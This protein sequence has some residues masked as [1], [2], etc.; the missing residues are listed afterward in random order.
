MRTFRHDSELWLPCPRSELFPFFADARNLQLITPLWLRF[1]VL[2]EGEI[3][4]AEG[5]LI[6]YRLRWRGLPLRW[7]TEITA[8]Q[9]PVRFVDEQRRGPYRL[10]V[11]EHLFSER[12][13]GTLVEDRV[14]YA[15]PGGLLAQRLLVGAD[16][17]RIFRFRQDELLHRFG[18]PLE[19]IEHGVS[20]FHID[21]TMATGQ[22]R[23]WLTSSNGARRTRITGGRSPRAASTG[24][25][26]ATPG[27]STPNE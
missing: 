24:S 6:D 11:H 16:V 12:D 7:Q 21:P 19:V 1:S 20:G 9:P 2:T 27:G 10:W 3:P 23:R 18:G 4:M 15:V 5:T 13:G 14:R 8:W 22:A 26:A 25:T 17:E